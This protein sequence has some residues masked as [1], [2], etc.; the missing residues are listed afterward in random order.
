LVVIPEG[1][2]LLPLP[3]PLPS[4]P[5]S[6]FPAFLV[7]PH[8]P[9]KNAKSPRTTHLFAANKNCR[10]TPRK[11]VQLKEKRGKEIEAVL[12][13]VRNP[14]RMTILAVTPFDAIFYNLKSLQTSE[15]K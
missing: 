8:H 15:N 10:F 6:L 1:D 3:L 13:P 12:L 11:P 14:F 7:N 4:D 2:L 5:Y 9:L